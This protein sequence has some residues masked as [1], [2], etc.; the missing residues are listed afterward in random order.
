MQPS[1][2][3]ITGVFLLAGVS[4]AMAA[5]SVDLTVVGTIT[6]S[7]C[8][9]TLS[10]GGLVDNGKVSAQDFP[11]YGEKL[12]PKSSLR[13]EVGCD[14]PVMMA[15]KSTDNR[16]GSARPQNGDPEG[17]ERSGF[18]LGR[19][20][21]GQKIGRY[22][23]ATINATA[24]DI[25]VGVIESW[26]GE[27]WFY[28]PDNSAWQPGWMRTANSTSGVPVPM[29]KFSTDV[30]VLTIL[31]PKRNLPLAEE[32]HIDGSATLDVFYL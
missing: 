19:A 23:L 7:A 1:R 25:P 9:P 3:F 4:N 8:T 31:A 12:L 14:T 17:E 5:S 6:P 21:N 32:I 22:E 18:G 16:L 10:N 2:V 15:L 27:K 30:V 24:D 11:E 29:T 13:L 26:D 20:S 28:A